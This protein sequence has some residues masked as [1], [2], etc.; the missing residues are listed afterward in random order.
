MRAVIQRV[1]K[2]SITIEKKLISSLEKGAVIFLGIDKDDNEDDSL[3]LSEKIANL[4]IFPNTENKMSFSILDLN[5]P[6]LVISCFT[7]LANCRKGNC[8]DFTNCAPPEK[9]KNLYNLFICHLQKQ[10]L[11]VF[12][13]I[14]QSYMQVSLTNDGPVT[15]LLDSKKHR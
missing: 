14:F 7:L 9:A 6:T 10:N 15:L 3:Y 12:S 4:R 1:T 13:G 8:P 2:A 11:K 5:L